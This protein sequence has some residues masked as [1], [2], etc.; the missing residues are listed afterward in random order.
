[1][2]GLI[3]LLWGVVALM[4]ESIDLEAKRK[5]CENNNANACLEVALHYDRHNI[6]D[7]PNAMK[8]YDKACSLKSGEAC[9]NLGGIYHRDK[10]SKAMHYL[11]LG[12]E[13]DY[14]TSCSAVATQLFKLYKQEDNRASKGREIL[15][16]VNRYCVKGYNLGFEMSCSIAHGYSGFEKE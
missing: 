6:K 1:M 8:Y 12:C 4:A 3:L 9:F 2:R 15:K 5:Q 7:M 13:Y 16:E 11:K 14:A 10:D